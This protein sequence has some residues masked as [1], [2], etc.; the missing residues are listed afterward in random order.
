MIIYLGE[1]LKSLRKAKGVT[2]ESFANYLGVSF[3]AVSKWERNDSYPDITM[4]PE[5]ADFFGVTVD[6]LLGVNRAK[7]ESEITELI[8][9]YDN[10]YNDGDEKHNAISNMIEKYRLT[11][12]FKSTKEFKEILNI[13]EQ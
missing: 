10:F 8:Y 5:I 9:N 13:L 12:D 11:D 7:K 3:Q 6:E 4:L 1:N 2:Q